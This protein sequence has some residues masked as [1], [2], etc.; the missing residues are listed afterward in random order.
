VNSKHFGDLARRKQT[1]IA[2]AAHERA[3]IAAAFKQLPSPFDFNQAVSGIGHTLKAHP[4]ITAGISSV[5]VSG[6]AGKLFKGAGQIVSL[7]RMALPLMAWWSQ[8]RKSS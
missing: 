7:S 6:F 5:L 1:L 8:R 4:M 2:K 3:E